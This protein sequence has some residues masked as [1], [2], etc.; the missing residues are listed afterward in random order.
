MVEIGLQ[1]VNFGERTA[2]VYDGVRGWIIDGELVPGEEI[3]QLELARRLGV[4]RTP[5][6]E[7]ISQ[8]E[9]DGL[10]EATGPHRLIRISPLSMSDLEEVYSLR[11][12]AE[13][14]TIWNSVLSLTVA[15]L[16]SLRKELALVNGADRTKAREAHRRFHAG[17]WK[18][19]GPRMRESLWMFMLHAE[20]YQIAF[21]KQTKTGQQRK[22]QEHQKIVE[23]C[24][25]ADRRAAR[26]LLID[27]FASTALVLMKSRG[28]EPKI[29]PEAIEMARGAGNESNN[30]M[31]AVP[32]KAKKWAPAR[33][34]RAKPPAT[35]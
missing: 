6:R 22:H 17:F 10:V 27:H 7:A 12:P 28:Y 11:I 13:A 32:K 33:S 1:T 25:E 2:T 8:L 16:A 35:G 30:G 20:R 15:D 3:S 14:L 24:E 23:A 31:P 21:V 5:L 26:D 34:R 29:L 19:A 4:S 18:G 9:R